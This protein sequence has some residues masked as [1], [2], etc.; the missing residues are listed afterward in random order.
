MILLIPLLAFALCA[1][2]HYI[3]LRLFPRMGLLD[4]PERYGLH[5]PRIPY[6]TGILALAVFVVFFLSIF[7]TIN[8]PAFA[9]A[10]A[11]K[12]FIINVQNIGIVLG[13]LL[14]GLTSFMDDRTPLP[15]LLR[16]YIQMTVAVIIF[17]TGSR[18][19]TITNPLESFT[20]IPYLKLDTMDIPSQFSIF[21]F[22]FS[23]FPTPLPLLSG[24]FT[25]LWLGLAMNALNWFDGIPGQVS[26]LSSLGFTVIGLLAIS[27]R[28]N[29]P[30]VAL[31]AFILAGIAGACLLFDFPVPLPHVLMG[32]TGA[33]FFGLM[34]AVLTI[35]AG[36]KVATAFLAFGVP[37]SDCL[38]VIARRIVAGRSPFSS[39]TQSEHL[40]H[41][42]LA[43]GWSEQKIIIL[44]IILGSAF[45]IGALF[46][47]TTGKFLAILLL[48]CSLLVLSQGSR[49]GMNTQQKVHGHNMQ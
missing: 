22:Q 34:L 46:L 21:N 48:I 4:F 25:I 19:Y 11:G 18:I 9:K 17:A 35:Y 6:P 24:L 20:G 13:I 47:N 5:R 29:Q 31:L 26:S 38:I 7:P 41:R 49:K 15:P 12:Q 1:M 8:F 37:F 40:H 14:L 45:G 39:G 3:A 2:L 36:G 23:I 32:D 42:L 16:L 27:A 43:R 10:T 33:M 44:N 30:Q 28:V